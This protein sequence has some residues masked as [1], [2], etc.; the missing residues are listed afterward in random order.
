MVFK[1][2]KFRLLGMSFEQRKSMSQQELY[3]FSHS[4]MNSQPFV[5]PQHDL[6]TGDMQVNS[7]LYS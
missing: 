4:M 2:G 1:F 5:I 7:L 6:Q 3:S